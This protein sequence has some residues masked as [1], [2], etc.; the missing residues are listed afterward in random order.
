[1]QILKVNSGF[2]QKQDFSLISYNEI[3]CRQKE[4]LFYVTFDIRKQET[5]F[6]HDYSRKEVY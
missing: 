4:V 1:M 3:S 6:K 2:G 5:N